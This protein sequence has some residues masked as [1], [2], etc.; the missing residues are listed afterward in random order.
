[1][2]LVYLN[3]FKELVKKNSFVILIAIFAFY[4]NKIYANLGVF[5]IDTF[6]HFD[7]GFNVMKGYLPIRDYWIVSGIV[8]D[9]MEAFFFFILGAGWETHV[10]HSSLFNAFI[11]LATFFLLQKIGLNK[12]YSF[13]YSIFFSILA[14]PISGTPFVDHHAIFFSLLGVYFFI[15]SIKTKKNYFWF[16]TVLFF[17]L[18]FFSKQVPA[19]YIFILIS[20][21]MLFYSYAIKKIEPIKYYVL[22]TFVL[23]LLTYITLLIFKIN[24]TDFLIQYIFYPPTIGASRLNDL[25][26][27]SPKDFFGEFKF[28]FIPIFILFYFQFQRY[29]NEKKYF[30]SNEFFIF[31]AML[32][33]SISLVFHQTITLNQNLTYFLSILLFAFLHCHLIKYYKKN[34]KL[35]STMIL[36]FVIFVTLKIH[37]SF[38]ETRKFHELKNV[39]L[40]NYIDA[41]IIDNNFKNLKWVTPRYKDNPQD[42]INFILESIETLK[43]DNRKKMVITHYQFLST[44]L[45]K[46]LFQPSRSYTLNGLSFPLKKS[47]YYEEYKLFFNNNIKNN[48]IQVI[49]LIDNREIKDRVVTE[50]LDESCIKQSLKISRMKIF[51]LN[52]NC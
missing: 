11:S 18:S 48:N 5:P 33:F 10:I 46:N 16:V 8:P 2:F 20:M 9:L 23:L 26:N 31:L 38:N 29:L 1:M 41:S 12:F 21:L 19:G 47:K 32:I 45:N 27:F 51:E 50:Y 24:F 13:L 22:S 28:I 43:K 30:K 35:I 4:I 44:I 7:A 25:L 14:Y 37:L 39:N 3:K 15:F 42:E 6:F 49:Y 40:N 36:S 17:I 52:K 34:E